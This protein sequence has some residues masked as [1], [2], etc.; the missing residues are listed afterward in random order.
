VSGQLALDRMLAGH[1]IE[2][3]PVL[4]DYLYSHRI[5]W[6]VVKK[7]PR[8]LKNSTEETPGIDNVKVVGHA[9]ESQLTC[10]SVVDRQKDKKESAAVE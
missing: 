8:L 7:V 4:R 10:P 3:S 5:S 6:E 1:I 2:I 9:E